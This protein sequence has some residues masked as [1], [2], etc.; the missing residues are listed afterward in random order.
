MHSRGDISGTPPSSYLRPSRRSS[1]SFRPAPSR[2]GRSPHQRS[3][4]VPRDA[5]QTGHCTP[6]PSPNGYVLSGPSQTV[7]PF[8][9]HYLV[10]SYEFMI[11]TVPQADRCVTRTV[12]RQEV[13]EEDVTE[14][15]ETGLA[16]PSH[17][18]MRPPVAAPHQGDPASS[19]AAGNSGPTGNSGRPPARNG[20]SSKTTFCSARSP[21]APA[22]APTAHPASTNTHAPAAGSCGSTPPR[23]PASRR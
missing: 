15:V 10:W 20:R 21:S 1:S 7:A 22:T 13:L 18:Q 3:L 2:N 16:T 14:D 19:N 6:A 8:S 23:Y 11:A 4:A 5:G 17:R 12:L 9:Q